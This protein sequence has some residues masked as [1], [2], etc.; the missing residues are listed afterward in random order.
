MIK[1]NC[2]VKEKAKKESLPT[3]AC[4]LIAKK[5][6]NKRRGCV[7]GVCLCRNFFAYL[8][9]SQQW[10]ARTWLSHWPYSLQNSANGIWNRCPM[11]RKMNGASQGTM[12]WNTNAGKKRENVI[13]NLN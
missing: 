12:L 3:G 8:W 2:F 10:Q 4:S 13:L 6:R 7:M 1:K 9:V 5:Q 11:N